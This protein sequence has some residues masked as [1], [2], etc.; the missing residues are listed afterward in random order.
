MVGISSHGFHRHFILIFSV[1]GEKSMR[2]RSQRTPH[3]EHFH[4]WPVGQGPLSAPQRV[5]SHL[6]GEDQ[7]GP[8]QSL[9]RI[10]SMEVFPGATSP[11]WTVV[12]PVGRGYAP[13]CPQ[14]GPC[15]RGQATFQSKIGEVAPGTLRSLT[16]N[17]PEGPSLSLGFGCQWGPRLT[18]GPSDRRSPGNTTEVPEPKVVFKT[19]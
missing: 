18:L 5:A 10:V 16:G 8:W 1:G 2:E 17:Q 6:K 9:R 19:T 3:G 11:S 14:A 7:K 15:A 13:G 4:P 12:D